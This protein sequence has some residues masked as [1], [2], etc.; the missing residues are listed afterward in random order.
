LQKSSRTAACIPGALLVPHSDS[1]EEGIDV[2]GYFYWSLID[3]FEWAGRFAPRF[4][5]YRVDFAT[6]QL[7]Q[8]FVQR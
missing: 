7:Q 8:I 3:N 6:L 1:A 4:G 2:R 5:L